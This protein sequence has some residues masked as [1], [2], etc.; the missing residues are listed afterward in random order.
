MLRTVRSPFCSQLSTRQLD[1]A[2]LQ[3]CNQSAARW[4]MAKRTCSLAEWPRAK[5]S[6]AGWWEAGRIQ[7]SSRGVGAGG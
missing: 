4:R 6:V 7:N 5:R 3:H 2:A 1:N